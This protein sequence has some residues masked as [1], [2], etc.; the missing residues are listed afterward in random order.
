MKNIYNLTITLILITTYNL[1]AVE[2]K[3]KTTMSLTDL[4]ANISTSTQELE[5]VSSKE[6][7]S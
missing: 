5:T 2:I 6:S 4:K 1:P 7:I 3:N